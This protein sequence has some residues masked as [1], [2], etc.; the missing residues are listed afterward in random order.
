[1]YIK[2]RKYIFMNF[3]SFS[4]VMDFY[5]NDWINEAMKWFFLRIKR[6]RKNVKTNRLVCSLK[7]KKITLR[8]CGRF[9][10]KKISPGR[11]AGNIDTFFWPHTRNSDSLV[12]LIA[13]CGGKEVHYHL[14]TAPKNANYICPC[15]YSEIHFYY[16]PP[17]RRITIEVTSH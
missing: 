2:L 6:A 7:V 12:D 9:I 14:L 15:I 5:E 1:M 17:Y 16:K 10:K 8:Q 4:V 13:K 3:F 11:Y